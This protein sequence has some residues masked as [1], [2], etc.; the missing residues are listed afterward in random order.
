MICTNQRVMETNHFKFIVMGVLDGTFLS[1]YRYTQ[2]I[3]NYPTFCP[4]LSAPRLDGVHD[5]SGAGVRFTKG[6]V[7]YGVM[8]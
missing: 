7:L 4:R 2:L 8:G 1:S 5:Q 6:S 3:P